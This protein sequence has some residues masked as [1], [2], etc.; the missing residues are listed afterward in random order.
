MATWEDLDSESKFD[1]D[2]VDEDAKIDVGLVATVTLEVEP[3]SDSEEENEVY[4]KIPRK[5]LIVYALVVI[6]LFLVDF[7]MFCVF[8]I[9]MLIYVNI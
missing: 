3:E 6:L 5:E 1:K 2:D 4:S 9:K 8:Y 7:S